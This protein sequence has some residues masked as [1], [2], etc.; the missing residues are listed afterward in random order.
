MATQSDGDS[1]EGSVGAVDFGS[2]VLPDAEHVGGR[3]LRQP[4]ALLL[5]L[6]IGEG[7]AEVFG[8]TQHEQIGLLQVPARRGPGRGDTRPPSRLGPTLRAG[9]QARSQRQGSDAKRQ[10]ANSTG[11]TSLYELPRG[12]W[13]RRRP[14]CRRPS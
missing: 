5:A 1:N 8:P 10:A 9:T 4:D 2:P 6:V 12:R 3:F 7:T 11:T 14:R 13:R